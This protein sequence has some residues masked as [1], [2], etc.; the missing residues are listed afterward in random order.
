M[1]SKWR[2]TKDQYLEV[3]NQKMVGKYVTAALIARKYNVKDAAVQNAVARLAFFTDYLGDDKMKPYVE[4]TPDPLG[5]EQQARLRQRRVLAVAVG[6]RVDAPGQRPAGAS[7]G[8]AVTVGRRTARC[9]RGRFTVAM[10][11]ALLARRPAACGGRAA[12][13]GHGRGDDGAAT[14]RRRPSNGQGQQ[15]GMSTGVRPADDELTGAAKDAYDRGFQAWVGGRSRGREDGVHRRRRARRP[16]RPDRATR[17][18][19]VLERLGDTQGALDA[20]RAAY[21]ANAQIRGRRWAPTLC[22]SREPDTVRTPSSSWRDKRAQ[23]P[24]SV[25]LTTYLAEVKSIEGDSPGCQQLAQQA[26]AKQPDFKDAMIVIARD[27]YRSTPLGP[28]EVRAP[29]H[30]RRR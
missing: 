8:R 5:P 20:Y 3:C 16:R 19:C 18:G 2:A 4:N 28:R 22:S 21:T 12:G 13:E 17:S 27:Y 11:L 10:A 29:G 15:V 14:R 23:S 30:P 24:D 6:R 26:L 25:R 7:A 9:M 1:R